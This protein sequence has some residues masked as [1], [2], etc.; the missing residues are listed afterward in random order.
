[1]ASNY[2]C[3][4]IL[5]KSCYHLETPCAMF[6]RTCACVLLKGSV[7]LLLGHIGTQGFILE[8]TDRA[9]SFHHQQRP[10]SLGE[11]GWGNHLITTDFLELW[12]EFP[13]SFLCRTRVLLLGCD[14]CKAIKSPAVECSSPETA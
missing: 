10:R 14:T 6:V 3:K 5:I 4:S 2:S 12:R 8:M 1:M 7:S 13:G 11:R 9:A